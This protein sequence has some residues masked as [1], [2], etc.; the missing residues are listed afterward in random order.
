M[1][2]NIYVTVSSV[3]VGVVIQDGAVID[4]EITAVGPQGADGPQGPQGIQGIQGVQ[5]PVGPVGPAG[6]VDPALILQYVYPVG[7]IYMSVNNVSPQSFVGG[8][9]SAWGTGRVPVAVD[10]GQTEF[11]TVEKTGGAKTHTLTVDQMPKHTHSAIS[12][13]GSGS[14]YVEPTTNVASWTVS[15][16]AVGNYT[17]FGYT[18]AV[19]GGQAHNNLQPYITCYMWKRTA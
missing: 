7:S 4:T 18:G 1:D 17:N 13:A 19:G 2:S 3:E 11:N 16:A 6:T 9:W 5:G 15:G 8:T 14:T 10:T 12:T